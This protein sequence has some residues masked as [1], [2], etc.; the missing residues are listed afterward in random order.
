MSLK[1]LY[2]NDI[3]LRTLSERIAPGYNLSSVVDKLKDAIRYED[4]MWR[5]CGLSICGVQ[6][7]LPLR[8][9]S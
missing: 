3:L 9:S 6:I 7:G 5:G 4:K 8:V 2:H 1:I